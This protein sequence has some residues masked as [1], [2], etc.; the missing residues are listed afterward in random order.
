VDELRREA[1]KEA[2]GKGLTF[3]SAD[4]HEAFQIFSLRI[5]TRPWAR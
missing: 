4:E 1:I 3:W 5:Q 2:F